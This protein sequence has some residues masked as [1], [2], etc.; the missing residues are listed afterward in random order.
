AR[1]TSSSPAART[2]SSPSPGTARGRRARRATS[3][4]T[5]P[6]PATRSWPRSRSASRAERPGPRCWR[7][8]PPR[9]PPRW[10]PRAPAT[11]GPGRRRGRPR[12]V[13]RAA[14]RGGRGGTG[15]GGAPVSLVTTSELVGA[16]PV[17]AFN[18]ITLEHAEAVLDGAAAAGRPV[19]LQVSQNAVRF[20]G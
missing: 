6:A 11:A 16:G 19:I 10:R 5:R 20:H 3:P 8:A 7:T 13:R 14:G 9:R 4:A 2:A 17:A 15:R 1:G 18:V 12:D